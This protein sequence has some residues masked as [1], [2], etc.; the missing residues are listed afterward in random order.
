MTFYNK[1]HDL[2][3]T[4]MAIWIDENAY[5]EDC[6]EPKMYFN[7]FLDVPNDTIVGGVPA[8]PIKKIDGGAI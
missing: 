1:P 7:L 6:D 8:K 5:K 3:Y 4:D 2:K